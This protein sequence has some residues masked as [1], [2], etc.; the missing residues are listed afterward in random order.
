[1]ANPL[2]VKGIVDVVTAGV[3]LDEAIGR[4][5]CGVVLILPE[6][7]IGNVQLCLLRVGPEREASAQGFE[8]ADSG[9]KIALIQ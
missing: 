4:I 3:Q 8:K 2:D 1:M 5:D 7:G 6:I 9:L